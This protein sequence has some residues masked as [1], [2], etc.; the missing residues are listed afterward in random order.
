MFCSTARAVM[1]YDFEDSVEGWEHEAER[2]A[3]LQIRSDHAHSGKS[4]L[5]AAFHFTQG[6]RTLQMRVLMDLQQDVSSVAGFEGFSAWIYIPKGPPRWEV[7][8]FARSG[9]HWDWTTG[10]RL[11]DLAPGWHRVQIMRSQ[12]KDPA[13][14][15]DLGIQV[16]NHLDDIDTTIAVDQVEIIQSAAPSQ[17]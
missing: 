12:I 14:L 8:M 9:D 4:A 10:E 3:A 16:S 1:L 2:P 6:S 11:K 7:V 13:N 5:S 17:P 15:K